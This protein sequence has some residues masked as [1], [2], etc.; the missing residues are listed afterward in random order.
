MTTA[1]S[2]LQTLAA[3]LI[4]IRATRVA[5]ENPGRN[6][7]AVAASY[8]AGCCAGSSG[9]CSRRH[10]APLAGFC[11]A[12]WPP[13]A[14]CR[15]RGWQS[16]RRSIPIHCRRCHAGRRHWRRTGRRARS[17]SGPGARWRSH[18]NAHAVGFPGCRAT[19]PT[20]NSWCCR[21]GRRIP[22]RLR[23]AGD[24]AGR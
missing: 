20:S 21:R 8:H 3:G 17:C 18:G 22:I 24:S 15:R 4:E 10:R 9:R 16:V 14:R 12:G 11:R 7:C 13:V 6:P 23:W 5:R 19:R 1:A 2:L